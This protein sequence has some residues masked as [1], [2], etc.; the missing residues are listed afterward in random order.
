MHKNKPKKVMFILVAALAVC[1][2][3]VLFFTGIFRPNT[4]LA[5]QYP[6][7]GVD[8]SEYQGEIDWNLLAPQISFAFIKATEGSGYA[9][10]HFAK[11][12]Q[13]AQAAQLPT[14]A[15]HFFSFSSSGQTQAANFIATVP[16][17]PGGLP[18]VVDIELYG[19][20][21]MRPP[22]AQEVWPQLDILLAMLEET[23]GQK[24]ILYTTM[25]AYNL[26][27]AGRYNNYPLWI[28][29]VLFT[30]TLPHGE[31]WLF[32]QYSDKGLLN[33]YNGKERYIDLNVFAGSQEE[34]QQ[35]LNQLL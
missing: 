21:K 1:A 4:F 13:G 26:Y 18:P 32:W 20:H 33:G 28:R 31:P 9:D 16:V 2:A 27:I 7:Q 14:G 8:V 29:E 24:P 11:N 12:W 3:F 22:N 17:N 25:P 10:P 34:W 15:Y 6:V 19:P 23:Y 5:N 30:P 35:Y